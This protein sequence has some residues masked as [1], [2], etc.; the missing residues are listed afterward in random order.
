MA[1]RGTVTR[2]DRFLAWLLYLL[3]LSPMLSF[4]LTVAII[5]IWGEKSPLLSILI[6]I[7]PFW[8]LGSV[9]SPYSIPIVFL[10][11]YIF[12]VRNRAIQYFVRF[13]TMQSLSLL[14]MWSL[15]GL[16]WWSQLGLH[17]ELYMGQLFLGLMGLTSIATAIASTYSMFCA[18]M[19]K[20][21]AIPVLSKAVKSHV[22]L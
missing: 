17:T 12:I 16:L 22:R 7:S 20:Y 14:T 21:G 15:V 9:L 18:I 2:L 11:L 3:T 8:L 13:H 19:G 4:F 1:L 6:Y 10:G 5:S